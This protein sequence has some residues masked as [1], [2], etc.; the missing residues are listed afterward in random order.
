M[1]MAGWATGLAL[2]TL[3]VPL[4]LH[5]QLAFD[6]PAAAA[7]DNGM[8]GFSSG[9]QIYTQ[10]CQGC[11]MADGRGAEGA[12]RYPSLAGNPTL[13]SAHYVAT[14]ILHGRR[15]MPAFARI[16]NFEFF[17]GPTWLN[18]VQIANVVNH[19]RTHFGNHHDNP[20][21]AADVAALHLPA[22]KN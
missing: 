6:A 16:D 9:E 8:L 2:L 20:I 3:G 7:D 12:G 15:N 18:D 19:V 1:K 11:H 22:E 14:T 21:S 10:I 4:S 17:F 5:A 13:A